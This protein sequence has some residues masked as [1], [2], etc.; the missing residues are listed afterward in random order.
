MPFDF[1]QAIK[2]SFDESNNALRVIPSGADF[3]LRFN[4][5]STPDTP[6][7]NTAVLY[8]FDNSG[9][10]ELRIKFADATVKTIADDT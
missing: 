4:D 7:A 5:A 6:A 3:I 10:Q 9:S 8:L 2:N 1:Q